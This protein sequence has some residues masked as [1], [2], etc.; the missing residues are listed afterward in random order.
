MCNNSQTYWLNDILNEPR[1]KSVLEFFVK[2]SRF[3]YALKKHG[4]YQAENAIIKGTDFDKFA[5]EYKEIVLDAEQKAFLLYLDGEPVGKLKTDGR[6]QREKETGS[7]IKRLLGYLR[8]IR[9]NLFHGTK[10]PN[11]PSYE[12]GGR[13]ARL[14]SDGIKA[15]DLF[16]A[17]NEDVETTYRV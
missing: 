10:Y 8:R 3:E 11:L 16:V 1:N 13:G 4:Y 5:K 15:I 12:E 2:F 9:N 6:Y 7:D 17:L 14:I